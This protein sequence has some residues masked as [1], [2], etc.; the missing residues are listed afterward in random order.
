MCCCIS[1]YNILLICHLC[2]SGIDSG[3]CKNC[4][5]ASPSTVSLL[6]INRP[7]SAFGQTSHHTGG[8]PS[9]HV[10][11]SVA[12]QAIEEIQILPGRTSMGPLLNVAT[13]HRNREEQQSVFF[14]SCWKKGKQRPLKVKI[15]Q[16]Q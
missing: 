12:S 1:L 9:L 4:I 6:G 7:P 16:G 14:F 15:A 8:L 13:N 3:Y 10:M 11:H 2:H 5:H